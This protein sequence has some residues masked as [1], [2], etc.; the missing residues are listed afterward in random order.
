MN[1]AI[2]GA[3]SAIASDV[4]RLLASRGDRLYLVGRSPHKLA[5]L[6][7]EV[8]DALAGSALQD[9]DDTS[10]AEACVTLAFRTLGTIDLAIIAHGLLGD[11]LESERNREV[12]E[13]IERTNYTS[14]VALVIPLANEMEHRRHGTLGVLSTV[15]AERGR[16][17]NYTYAAA[18][19]AL[20]TY[21]EG[22]RSRLYPS[23]V[24]VRVIKLGPVDTPMT[25]SHAKNRLFATSAEAAQQIVRALFGRRFSTYV[26]AYWAPIMFVVRNLPERAFQKIRALS[27]R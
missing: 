24:R 4:A 1:I 19:S 21:L 7:D 27:E 13:S 6:C 16:P 25:E 20:N 9:F 12:A 3:T 8:G 11:Q 26:P 22:V 23:G 15:A 2:F 17:R 18:K 10:A 14:V 5:P